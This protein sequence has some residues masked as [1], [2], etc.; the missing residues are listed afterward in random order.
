LDR[1]LKAVGD[2]GSTSPLRAV[3]D[4]PKVSEEEGV[5]ICRESLGLF[6]GEDGCGI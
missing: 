3:E 6:G 1:V 4:L 2:V 5:L